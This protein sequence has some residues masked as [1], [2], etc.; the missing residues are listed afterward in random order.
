MEFTVTPMQNVPLG[1]LK[2]EEFK[3][4]ELNESQ[5]AVYY[6]SYRHLAKMA[7]R[8]GFKEGCSGYLSTLING[9]LISIGGMA[10]LRAVE[11]ILKRR[12]LDV[13]KVKN[14]I[15]NRPIICS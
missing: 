8:D 2:S 9:T 15:D 14:Y 7:V 3:E 12:N 10:M 11:A 4:L 6:A 13:E 1:V 5:L